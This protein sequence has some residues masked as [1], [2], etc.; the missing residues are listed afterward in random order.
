MKRWIVACAVSACVVTG[1]ATEAGAS[2]P[3]VQACVGTTFSGAAHTLRDLGAAPGTLGDI[4]SGLAQQP[5]I[6]ERMNAPIWTAR[7]RLEWGRS[8]LTRDHERGA[9]QLSLAH[10]AAHPLGA[11][12]IVAEAAALARS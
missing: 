4:V 7:T 3:V 12:D 2:E 1:V 8:L 10:D 5:E 6:H 9:V 11:H